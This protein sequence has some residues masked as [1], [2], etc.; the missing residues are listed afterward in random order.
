M[1]RS[2]EI[3]GYEN[4]KGIRPFE[5]WISTLSEATRIRVEERLDRLTYG[6]FG[7]HKAVGKGV[8]EPRLFFGPGYRIYYAISGKR[9]VLLLAGGDK[10]SQ[11]KDIRKAQS[12]WNQYQ[13]EQ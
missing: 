11:S 6:N 10:K 9:I 7:D 2:W 12:Y 8:Y 13:S 4:D 5:A 3:R 1:R